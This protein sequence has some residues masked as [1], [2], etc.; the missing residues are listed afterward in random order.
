MPHPQKPPIPLEQSSHAHFF[1]KRNVDHVTKHLFK[2]YCHIV[3]PQ[4][5]DKREDIGGEWVRYATEFTCFWT[6]GHGVRHASFFS[7][8]PPQSSHSRR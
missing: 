8:P 4:S 6:D 1:K 7:T 5:L 2:G 3:Y